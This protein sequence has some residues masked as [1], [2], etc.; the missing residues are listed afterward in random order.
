MVG[1]MEA[2]LE[3]R[4]HAGFLVCLRGDPIGSRFEALKS[5]KNSLAQRLLAMGNVLTAAEAHKFP[6]VL[7]K[8]LNA[9]TI[10][11]SSQPQPHPSFLT[12]PLLQWAELLRSG[13][14]WIIDPEMEPLESAPNVISPADCTIRLIADTNVHAQLP[15]V[16]L[17]LINRLAGDIHMLALP[18]IWREVVAGKNRIKAER[19]RENF[20]RLMGLK[21]STWFTVM[22]RF[23]R[24]PR[25]WYYAWSTDPVLV[26]P[27][28]G[29]L[30]VRSEVALVMD[31]LERNYPGRLLVV[32]ITIDYNC[33]LLVRAVPTESGTLLV[34]RL[35]GR[36]TGTDKVLDILCSVMKPWLV[37]NFQ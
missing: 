15:L 5:D 25:T 20:K 17:E 14:K 11:T 37:P 8:L 2:I 35:D 23:M 32:Y 16:L 7:E 24:G 19:R 34:I 13:T 36:E 18:E 1:S 27:P 33:E 21:P 30:R 22:N 12:Q 4:P 28:T 31:E 6:S 3:K 29:D 26:E 9:A 10:A